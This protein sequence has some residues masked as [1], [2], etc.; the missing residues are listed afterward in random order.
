MMNKEI[1]KIIKKISGN[2]LA[3]GI[4]EELT[5]FLNDNKNI[6]ECTLLNA[7][8]KGKTKEKSKKGKSISIK[9]IR[10]KFKKKKIDYII[11]NYKD[12]ESYINTFVKDSVFINNKKLY[13]FGD[14]DIELIKKRY[15]RYKTN[16]TIKQI[17]DKYLVEIDNSLAR[18]N[19]IKERYYRIIDGFS[20]LIEI[21][22]DILM[23]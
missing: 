11:C 13:Y 3:I 14:I 15:S 12:I 21:I 10:K 19:V 9:K 8:K 7:Y 6:T 2:V 22:G 1:I 20:R 5:S 16:I 4:D 18:N 17:S 23:S